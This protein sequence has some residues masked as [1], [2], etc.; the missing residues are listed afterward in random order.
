V[1]VD[2]DALRTAVA[3]FVTALGSSVVEADR[4]AFHLVEANLTGHDSH[5]VGLLPRYV[6]ALAEGGLQPDRTPHLLADMGA[7]LQLDGQHG[8]GQT[9][10]EAA[11]A[12][13]AERA[14]RQGC[15]IFTVRNSH[16]VGR[17]GQ[18]AIQLAEQALVSI[19]FVNVLGRPIVAPW[20]GAD[21][22][23]GTN[24][25]AVG[26]PQPGAAPFVLDF[27]TS[28]VAQG[29]LRVAH[30]EGHPVRSGLL[31][32]AQGRTTTDPR[33]AVIP[34]YGAILPF[35]AHK[36]SGLAMACEL[37]GGALPGGRTTRE[38]PDQRRRITNGFLA[39]VIDPACVSE[40]SFAEEVPGFLDWVRSSRTAE[41]HEQVQVAGEPE[42]H[43][44]AR[45]LA[46]GVRIDAT[47]WYEILAAGRSSGVD[48]DRFL[49]LA[50]PEPT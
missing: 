18:Y 28:E 9:I 50:A 23:H 49:A 12:L 44:R 33:Y 40:T 3:A 17:V 32:D 41:G 4:V 13:A 38:P 24:P 6:E 37:L 7:F 10:A 15:C 34:P 14:R 39:I 48:I 11:A 47:T 20:G 35:G 27:A 31:L 46:E 21:G 2:A 45:R 25:F 5:G 22:R 36:G 43:C 30:N 42:R 8:Y 26:I 19:W 1:L 29:K 16:H